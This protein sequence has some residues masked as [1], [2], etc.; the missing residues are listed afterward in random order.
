MCYQSTS[1][2]VTNVASTSL[3]T[4]LSLFLSHLILCAFQLA[5][6]RRR[7]TLFLGHMPNSNKRKTEREVQSLLGQSTY[8]MLIYR[9][10]IETLPVTNSIYNYAV[11]ISFLV[12]FNCISIDF[13]SL[14]DIRGRLPWKY[15]SLFR[16]KE[17][18]IELIYASQCDKQTQK[19][20]KSNQNFPQVKIRICFFKLCIYTLYL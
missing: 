9:N 11:L 13:F 7:L 5:K 10:E 12:R 8:Y 3:P 20:A 19:F 2:W 15:A 14:T 1:E 18:E 6:V 17:K 4:L 16:E